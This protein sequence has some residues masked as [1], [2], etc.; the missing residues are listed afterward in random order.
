M[1]MLR[2]LVF[3]LRGLCDRNLLVQHVRAWQADIGRR[4]LEAEK[5]EQAAGCGQ[6]G[7][8]EETPLPG[9][10]TETSQDESAYEHRYKAG[11]DRM[12][13]VP[14]TLLGR[15]LG[16]L[17]PVSHETAAG[18][19]THSLGEAV[20]QPQ[21]SDE[22]H[23][24]DSGL[25]AGIHIMEQ[26]VHLRAQTDDEV[27][28]GGKQEPKT[29]YQFLRARSVGYEAVDETGHA[30]DYS[31]QSQEYSQLGL[32]KSEFG[33]QGRHGYAEILPYEIEQGVSD[34]QDDERTPL[35]II[36]FLL[37]ALVHITNITNSGN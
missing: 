29:H 33:L 16:W 14:D 12:G 36:V 15:Q 13:A 10:I 6:D 31:V 9:L 35:P 18:R 19:I 20:D 4:I 2:A 30:I 34:H 3:L 1:R 37:D 24:S 17:Y 26:T 27:D 7:G 8:D 22:I 32:V 11:S 23:Q 21:G 25:T 28:D 5:E